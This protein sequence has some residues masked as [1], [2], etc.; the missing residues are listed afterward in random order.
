MSYFLPPEDNHYSIEHHLSD[1]DEDKLPPNWVRKTTTEGRYYYYNTR[2][3]EATW[4][5]ELIDPDTGFLMTSQPDSPPSSPFFHR[6][7]SNIWSTLSIMLSQSVQTLKESARLGRR[8]NLSQDV[9]GV[10]ECVRQMMNVADHRSLW[11][12]HQILLAAVDQLNLT[13]KTAS[14][15]ETVSKVVSDAEEVELAARQFMM[16]A[17]EVEI[18]PLAIDWRSVLN[19]LMIYLKEACAPLL[20]EGN[21]DETLARL[22]SRHIRVLSQ[23]IKDTVDV[24]HLLMRLQNAVHA[25]EIEETYHQI[26]QTVH[27][28]GTH[29]SS[30]QAEDAR[31]TR[32]L[33]EDPR[34]GE[35]SWFLS[36]E[37]G[38]NELVLNTEG[39]VKCGTLHGLV[40]RLT[41]HDQLDAKFNVTFLLTYR[42][43][44][45]TEEL[46]NELFK[47]YQMAPPEGL[48]NDEIETWKEKKLKLVRLRVFNVIKS[49]LETYCNEEGDRTFLP[50]LS[51]F[52]DQ[53]IANSMT[54]GADQ[55]TKLIKKRMLSEDSGQI[56]KMKLNI[57]TEDMPE[58]ILPKNLKR[59]QLLELDPQELARQMTIMDFRLYNRIKP[60]ECLDKNWGKP[61]CEVHIAANIKALIEHSN[62][63][64]A[65]VTDSILTREEVKK[66]ATVLKYWICVAEKCRL[67][68]N[69]NTCMAILSAFDNGSIGRLKRTWELINARSLQS[70]HLIRRLMGAQRNFNEYR[71]MIR[72]VN[73]PCIPFLGIYLQDLTFIEDG[74][75]NFLKGSSQLINFAKRTKTAEVILD[76]QQY[77]S[78]HYLLTVVPDI[79]EFIKTHLQSSRDEEELYNLSLKLEPR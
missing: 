51:Q 66:R 43:F 33:D 6:Q 16:R 13:A 49:W 50:I 40:Q 52:T 68:N 28:Q 22:R 18:Q 39:G 29:E 24:G 3:K 69:Y 26:A 46:F 25:T 12:L 79:Q 70:L 61:D 74:N 36:A 73:P 34:T 78:T 31:T 44:C 21:L 60:V 37:V 54:F 64:T 23:A 20:E 45:T 65:W 72:R 56:R 9:N 4:E 55:L 53:V 10:I 62:Q 1:D 32:S 75:A 38:S 58:P 8:D 59:I 76:L 11:D 42:S 14:L 27:E 63:V 15:R 77:Q 17:E 2:T 5:L 47:R 35:A 30:E 48:T 71:E 19:V 67:L 7:E 57:R 41:K